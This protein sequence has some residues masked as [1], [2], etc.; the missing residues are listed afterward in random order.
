MKSTVVFYSFIEGTAEPLTLQNEFD[1][2]GYKDNVII[3]GRSEDL[4]DFQLEVTSPATN[5]APESLH[6]V[7]DRKPLDRTIVATY[8]A[9]EAA[10][11]QTKPILFQEMKKG[12]E[13]IVEEFGK[14]NVPPPWQLFT[15]SSNHGSGERAGNLQMIQ[16]VFE[17]SFEFDVLFHSGSAKEKLTSEVVSKKI[18]QA[19]KDFSSRYQ[20]IFKAVKP[21]DH[22]QYDPF[23]KS[24]FSNLIGG[25]GYFS[26]DQIVDRSYDSAY[27]EDDEGFWEAAAEA[28]AD[29]SKPQLEGPYSLFTGVPSRSFFPRGFLWDE[30]F[31]LLPIADW[32]VGLVLE[33]LKSWFNTMD[34]DGWVPREQI[35]GAEARSKVP[36]E[37]AVQYPHYANPPTLFTV[38]EL[39]LDKVNRQRDTTV[40]ERN[41]V[42]SAFKDMYPKLKL[43]Y[44]WYRRTQKGDIT[45]YDR[46]AFSTKEGYRWRGRT[47]SHILTSGLDDYPR[48]QPPHPGELH[49]DL[50]SWIGLMSRNMK[51][52]ATELGETDDAKEFAKNEEAIQKNIDDLHWDDKA[53][54]FCDATIDDYEESTHVCHKGY[55]SIFPF[56]TGMIDASSPRLGPILDL[57]ADPNE[58]WSPYGIRSLSKAD[59]F[60][61]TAENYWRS[62]V[63]MPI[64]YLIVDN[65]LRVAQT[66]GSP[67]AERARDLY[68]DLR[69]NLVDTVYSSWKETGFAWE[70]YN[71]ETGVGQRT[72]QFTGW[73]S[74]VVKLMSM[75]DIGGGGKHRTFAHEEL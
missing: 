29:Q 32:D 57:I 60:Y 39:L 35:L 45:T 18:A 65:L 4:G 74:L 44:N 3:T 48:A 23:S 31:H 14:N 7:T 63:W 36:P 30:G 19:T 12:L 47:P 34:Q 66:K 56:F 61:G 9:P 17:G 1:E 53:K 27:D 69:K 40:D 68:T 24:M 11:W 43:N 54:T 38:I 49:V 5:H 46:K 52:I 72:Q 13:T 33:V 42:V 64:N 21:F 71:P 37:F 2:L 70:Q 16:K 73:T 75:P 6:P 41:A 67:Y 22:R 20:S 51:R 58:L 26:G 55:I 59:E 50:I 25:I 8:T 28:R 62:P 15:L 10:L